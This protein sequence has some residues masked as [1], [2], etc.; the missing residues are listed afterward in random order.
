MGCWHRD[1]SKTFTMISIGDSCKTSYGHTYCMGR[2]GRE[3]KTGLGRVFNF[4]SGC[5]D[6]E[7][8]LIYMNARPQL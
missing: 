1:L 3:P 4:K 8:L 5:F 7:Y 6:D 2:S